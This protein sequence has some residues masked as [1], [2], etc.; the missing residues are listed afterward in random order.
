MN[1]SKQPKQKG[2]T[3]IEVVL[4]LAIAALIFLIVFLAVPALQ[5]NQRDSQ[6]RSDLGRTISQLQTYA[7]NHGGTLP[8]ADPALQSFIG[9]ATTAGY[10]VGNGSTFNDPASGSTYKVVFNGSV[11]GTPTGTLGQ[12]DYFLNATC[13]N[14]TVTTLAGT[15]RV[16]ILTQLEASSDYYCVNN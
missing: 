8:G 11:S 2:F 14:G 13:T 15:R 7:S 16:A 9:S 6:R 5:R 12:V 4:V 10:L 1:K 3:I